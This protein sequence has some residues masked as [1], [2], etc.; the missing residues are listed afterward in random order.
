MRAQR[1]RDP[2]RRPRFAAAVQHRHEGTYL[3]AEALGLNRKT[4]RGTQCRAGVLL[5]LAGIGRHG[6]DIGGDFGHAGESL[7]D[8]AGDRAGRF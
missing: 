3:F 5:G 1:C 4:P 6:L 2:L 8:V 7:R